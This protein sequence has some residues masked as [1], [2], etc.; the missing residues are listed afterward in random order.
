M[1]ILLW[2]S[3]VGLAHFQFFVQAI[4]GLLELSLTEGDKSGW[5]FPAKTAIITRAI[6]QRTVS[7]K[8]LFLTHNNLNSFDR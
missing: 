7:C 3:L 4:A 6:V 8:Q 2:F 5:I 1:T